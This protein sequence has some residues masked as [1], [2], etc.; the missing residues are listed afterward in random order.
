MNFSIAWTNSLVP[1][2]L[3]TS[4]GKKYLD[5]S[6][7]SISNILVGRTKLLDPMDNFL[8][9]SWT[10]ILTFWQKFE[11]SKVRTFYLIFW[12]KNTSQK[13]LVFI[14]CFLE[15]DGICK[16]KTD[17]QLFGWKMQ[18]FE[19]CR[20]WDVKQRCCY[21]IRCPM[22]HGLKRNI[23]NS[24]IGNC[25]PP[26]TWLSKGDIEKLQDHS[27]FSSYGGEIRSLTLKIE[28]FLNNEQPEGLKQSHLTDFFQ[29][30]N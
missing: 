26:L 11:S 18:S 19:W 24:F 28:T 4:L 5:I 29:V 30:V 6:N 25:S 16:T 14:R 2:I 8:S 27:F 7:L 20:K 13:L 17:K 21:K 23:I 1:W 15:K 10:F 9:F 3:C 22:K 12:L